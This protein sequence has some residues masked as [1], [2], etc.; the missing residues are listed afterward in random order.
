MTTDLKRG[1]IVLE[2]VNPKELLD[3]QEANLHLYYKN[4]LGVTITST[5]KWYT[6]IWLLFSNPFRYLLTGRIRY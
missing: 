5:E 1:R 6:R 4:T 2:E 3:E